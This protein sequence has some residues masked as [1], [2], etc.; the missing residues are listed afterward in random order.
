MRCS[1][2]FQEPANT[3]TYE[4]KINVY[5]RKPAKHIVEDGQLGR[6]DS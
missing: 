6:S 1:S 2:K 5:G 4:N 3:F